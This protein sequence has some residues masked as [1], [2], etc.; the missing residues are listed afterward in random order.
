[1]SIPVRNTRHRP[2]EPGSARLPEAAKEQRSGRASV[3]A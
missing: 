3:P 2:A 1:M